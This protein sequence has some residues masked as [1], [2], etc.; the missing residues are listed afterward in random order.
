MHF[1]DASLPLES[2]NLS[3]LH[4]KP[5]EHARMMEDCEKRTGKK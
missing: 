5:P 3:V 1:S 4:K 2:Q